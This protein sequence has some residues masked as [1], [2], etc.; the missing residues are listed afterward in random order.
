MRR[1]VKSMPREDR[2]EM[3]KAIQRT[4]KPCLLFKVLAAGRTIGSQQQIREEVK[5]ALENSKSIDALLLGMYQQFNDQIGENAAL[6]T[7]LCKVM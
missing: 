3:C 2:D 6:I 5:F 1:S 4:E 7:E